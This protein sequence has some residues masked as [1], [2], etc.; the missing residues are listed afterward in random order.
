MPIPLM[1]RSLLV[2]LSEAKDLALIPKNP[3]ELS[4][5]SF[6]A[7]RTTAYCVR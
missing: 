5:R 7:L 4:V 3:C 2:I 6:A 1:M